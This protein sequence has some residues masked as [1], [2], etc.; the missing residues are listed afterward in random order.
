MVARNLSYLTSVLR[1]E[2]EG[3]DDSSLLTSTCAILGMGNILNRLLRQLAANDSMLDISERRLVYTSMV[4]TAAL[5]PN[6][7]EFSSEQ[8]LSLTS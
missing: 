8:N 4:S 3:D 2:K 6:H 7:A 1:E 5:P